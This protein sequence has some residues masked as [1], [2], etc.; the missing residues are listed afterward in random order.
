[1]TI[2][3]TELD[4]QQTPIGEISLR[5]RTDPALGGKLIYEVKLGD[6]F[7]MSSLFTEGERELANLGLRLLDSTN[8][9]VVVG[10]LGLGHTAAAVLDNNSVQ[11]LT[12]VEVMPAVIEWH[13]RH[14]VPLAKS[15]VEDARCHLVQGDFFELAT[16]ADRGFDVDKPGH[17]VDAVLL[18]I[19][20]A[21]DNYLAPENASFYS[22][23]GLTR[24]AQKICAGGVFGL[25]SNDPVDQ[26]FVTLLNEVFESTD[27]HVVTFENPYTGGEA[28]NTIYLSRVAAQQ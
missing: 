21:P 13:R 28:S 17:Q 18:D 25:W 6:E 5:R 7:L 15:L 8:L 3:F 20:H 10:G 16:S 4:Y 19:D 12:V 27:T 9:D 23:N 11:R 14:L 24:M 1:M 26:S 22:T 2:E